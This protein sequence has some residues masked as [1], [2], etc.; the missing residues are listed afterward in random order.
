MK[1]MEEDFL[2]VL[3]PGLIS[4]LAQDLK[5]IRTDKHSYAKINGTI[6]RMVTA[7][8]SDLSST[9]RW[10]ELSTQEQIDLWNKCLTFLKFLLAR[11][12]DG[13]PRL[14]LEEIKDYFIAAKL[15]VPR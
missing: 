4:R 2:A 9:V 15:I 5:E 10:R 14:F 6:G 11:E 8:P 3:W 13:L 1:S 7:P 12:V